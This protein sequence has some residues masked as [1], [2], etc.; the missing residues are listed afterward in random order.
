MR[1]GRRKRFDKIKERSKQVSRSNP[2][3]THGSRNK[4]T[5]RIADP[6][7]TG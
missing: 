2:D 6:R 7:R 1:V 4:N 5:I 3:L